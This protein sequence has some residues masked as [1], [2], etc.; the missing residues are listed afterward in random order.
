ERE[1]GSG[2][3]SGAAVSSWAR[4]RPRSM[5]PLARA[6]LVLS[7]VLPLSLL[8][9]GCLPSSQRQNTRALTPAD[10]L[11]MRLAEEA[12]VDTLRLVWTAG[13]PEASPLELPTSMVWLPDSPGG[14]LVVADTRRA[15]LHVFSPEGDYVGER[16]PEGLRYPYL[17][18][19]RGDTVVVY[20]RGEQRLDF[21]MDERVVRRLAL[22]ADYAAVLATDDGLWAKRT[23]EET[24][25]LA[26]LG[27]D[28]R[29]AARYRLP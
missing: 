10:S 17:A 1:I 3:P 20:S 8:L 27:A 7:L 21:V 11:S 14:R 24:V 16:R 9:A 18:G 5:R 2:G 22:P 4:L 15:S 26:R 25:Y 29:E 19:T 13:A 23:E 28:G 12:P 6:A